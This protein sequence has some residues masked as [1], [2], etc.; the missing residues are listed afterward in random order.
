[1]AF[2]YVSTNL[3]L[4]HPRL[5]TTLILLDPVIQKNPS[6]S[7]GSG[8]S[9]ARASTIRRDLWPSR[10]AAAESFR[11]SKFYQAWDERVLDRWL[12]YG[13]RDLPTA[14]YPGDSTAEDVDSPVTLTTTKHQE[15]FTFLRANFNSK[16]EHGKEVI[17]RLTH[18][19][20]DPATPRSFPFYRPEPVRT[21]H[22]LPFVRPSVLY[23][24][25]GSSWLSP[26]GSRKEKMELTGSGVGG[27]GGVKE[28][29]VKEVV[30][31]N[32]GH[33]VAMEAVEACADAT[34]DWLRGELKR[35]REEEDKFTQEWSTRTRRDKLVTSEEWKKLIDEGPSK[36]RPAGKGKL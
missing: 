9:P 6:A 4:I 33:L 18:A 26:P 15:V 16:D 2:R 8:P 20:F 7:S 28:G 13:L 23:I 10:S 36:D 27:S 12:Q 14:I 32:T 11:K 34:A 25:G 35:W 1:M 5:L 3:A 31:E 30:L 19:D 24:F 22:N 17:N 29:R 21:Y